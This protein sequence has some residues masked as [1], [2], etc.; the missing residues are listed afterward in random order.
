M[1]SGS[2]SMTF[3]QFPREIRDLVY[4]A[5]VPR[6]QTYT[7]PS[8]S[9]TS[10]ARIIFTAK[11]DL[12]ILFTSK[13]VQ[14]EFLES[15]CAISS[16]R[17]CFPRAGNLSE[18]LSPEQAN[19]LQHVDII[20]HL[21]RYHS[22]KFYKESSYSWKRSQLFD[23]LQLFRGDE[24]KRKTCRFTIINRDMVEFSILGGGF[25]DC[26]K[27]LDGFDTDIVAQQPGCITTNEANI[28]S[29]SEIILGPSS[30]SHENGIVCNEYH[31][32]EFLAKQ[33]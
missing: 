9:T 15:L 18:I 4:I 16:I 11:P 29:Y 20:F 2:D 31:P 14:Y 25:F 7:I 27:Y 10:I 22:K 33:S 28:Q 13:A 23:G 32:R 8:T 19:L 30:V 24:I 6:E 12:G 21:I 3:L 26:L 17:V 1:A 5:L